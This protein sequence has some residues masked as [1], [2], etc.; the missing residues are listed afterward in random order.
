M[1]V[2][3]TRLGSTD[4]EEVEVSEPVHVVITEPSG[5]SSLFVAVTT[6]GIAVDRMEEDGYPIRSRALT[7]V[8]FLGEDKA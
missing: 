2:Q 8:E 1:I 5:E 4:I 6:E 7:H 3:F